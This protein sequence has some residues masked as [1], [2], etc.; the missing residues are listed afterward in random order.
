[1][2][3]SMK[4]MQALQQVASKF[5]LSTHYTAVLKLRIVTFVEVVAPMGSFQFVGSCVGV[6][7]IRKKLLSC[8][9]S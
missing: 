5:V 7:S 4:K 3:V 8:L 1:M 6:G 9:Y 2:N